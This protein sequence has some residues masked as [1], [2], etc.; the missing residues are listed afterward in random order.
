MASLNSLRNVTL[1][2]IAAAGVGWYGG[3]RHEYAELEHVWGLALRGFCAAVDVDKNRH[4][5]SCQDAAVA[6]DLQQRQAQ[7]DADT[8]AILADMGKKRG[9]R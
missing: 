3:Y 2:A 5:Y 8:N 7:R 4:W 1:I 6:L 9:K